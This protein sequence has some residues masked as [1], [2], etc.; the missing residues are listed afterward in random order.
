M[1]KCV[2]FLVSALVLSASVGSPTRGLVSAKHAAL[3]STEEAWVNPYVTTGLVA[4]WDG[5]WNYKNGK[6]ISSIEGGWTDC[7]G[8]YNLSIPINGLWSFSN[9]SL[10][11]KKRHANQGEVRI[12]IPTLNLDLTEYSI[13]I[14]LKRGNDSYDSEFGMKT[15]ANSFMLEA[16]SNTSIRMRTYNTSGTLMINYGK[17]VS[18]TSVPNTLSLTYDGTKVVGYVNGKYAVQSTHQMNSLGWI[19]LGNFY[20]YGYGS[21]YDIRIFR[22]ALSADE[23]MHNYLVDKERFGL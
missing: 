5:E 1:K 16:Y 12:T 15:A 14:C 18:D 2:L 7:V 11:L 21:L 3:S 13:E 9:I 23:V 10:D 6:H 8:N 17:N 22:R 19:I 4:M 20:L